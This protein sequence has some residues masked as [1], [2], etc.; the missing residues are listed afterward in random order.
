LKQKPDASTRPL[1]GYSVGTESIETERLEGVR[2]SSKPAPPG[3][4]KR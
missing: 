2:L 4:E 3:S 1:V